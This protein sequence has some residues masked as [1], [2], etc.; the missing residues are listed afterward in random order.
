MSTK[1]RAIVAQVLA[2]VS[3]ISVLSGPASGATG[4]Q[5]CTGDGQSDERVQMVYVRKSGTTD[6]YDLAQSKGQAHANKM[7]DWLMQKSQENGTTGSQKIRWYCKIAG[8]PNV[9]NH[10]TVPATSWTYG[11]IHNYLAQNG[12]FDPLR[13]Y[14]LLLS[15]KPDDAGTE[16]SAAFQGTSADEGPSFAFIF[17]SCWNSAGCGTFDTT[18]GAADVMTHEFFHTL[19]AVQGCPGCSDSAPNVTGAPDPGHVRDDGADKMFSGCCGYTFGGNR[20]NGQ[21]IAA[22]FFSQFLDCGEDDYWSKAP[23]PGSFLANWPR[24][25]VA[26]SMFLTDIG[27]RA[28]DP[29]PLGFLDE[30]TESPPLLKTYPEDPSSV[31]PQD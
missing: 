2:A 23:T 7:T 19:S 31:E 8:V 13:K 22:P 27:L 24:F 17:K 9:K 6:Y 18:N 25:N 3:V 28:F 12:Y 26:G 30:G 4:S 20:C 5:L 21:G 10:G 11:G 29:A 1:R 15:P 16:L 14:I